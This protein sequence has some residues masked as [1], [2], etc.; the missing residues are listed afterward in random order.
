MTSGAIQTMGG[1]TPE[2]SK[3]IGF[4]GEQ[5]VFEGQLPKSE[6]GVIDDGS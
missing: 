2:L 3:K 1:M 5:F 6:V 4:G